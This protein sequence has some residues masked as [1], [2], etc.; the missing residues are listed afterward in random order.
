MQTKFNSAFLLFLCFLST[1]LCADNDTRLADTL[2]MLKKEFPA[3]QC[4][5]QTLLSPYEGHYVKKEYWAEL[6]KTKSH[7][8]AGYKES[9][10]IKIGSNGF[11]IASPNWH[12]GAQ[13]YVCTFE[14]ENILWL[15]NDGGCSKLKIDYQ[16]QL[17][18]SVDHYDIKDIVS[19]SAKEIPMEGP[20][21]RIGKSGDDS[22]Y[23]EKIFQ[24][25]CYTS[26]VGEKWC[27]GKDEITIDSK[28]HKVY[29]ELD[30]ELMPR[31]GNILTF[32]DRYS[33]NLFV[34]VL[35]KNGW[36]IFQD[37]SIDRENYIPV[38]PQTDKP[39]RIL[40]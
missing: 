6:E 1:V 39:W 33:D 19:I 9:Y 20:F 37:T 31:Y 11:V 10:T 22:A 23:F 21:I 15:C 25:K 14:K 28:I 13:P 18:I 26:D 2:V 4:N 36:K 5:Q 29:L 7:P 3:I 27:F 32:D 17:F 35:Y 16:K 40:Q 24:H 8:L 38:N 12:E 30:I 34:F